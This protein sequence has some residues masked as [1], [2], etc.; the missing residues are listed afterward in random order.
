M[1]ILSDI[2]Q[3]RFTRHILLPLP[4]MIYQT[5]IQW[6]TQTQSNLVSSKSITSFPP[7][8]PLLT[9]NVPRRIPISNLISPPPSSLRKPQILA[10]EP[11]S[12]CS[13]RTDRISYS[14]P[15]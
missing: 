4:C 5:Q 3:R 9:Q 7:P 8:L 12:D 13:M 14:A 10:R 6:H 1:C 11:H 2:T 15:A